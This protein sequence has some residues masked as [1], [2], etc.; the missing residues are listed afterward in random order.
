ME[1]RRDGDA[2]SAGNGAGTWAGK[3]GGKG[4]GNAAVIDTG[5]SGSFDGY[6]AA[7][8]DGN[9]GPSPPARTGRA[10]DAQKKEGR[11]MPAPVGA[12][13]GRENSG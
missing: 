11:T 8:G 12:L 6:W 4:D 9:A 3:G 7:N 13:E 1:C 10:T 5:K 2:L